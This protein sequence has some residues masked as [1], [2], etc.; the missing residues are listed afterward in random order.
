MSAAAYSKDPK[1]C[2]QKMNATKDFEI[3]DIIKHDCEDLPLFTHEKCFA[4]TAVSHTHRVITLAFRGSTAVSQIVDEMISVL[5]FHKV[6][7]P[8]G[9]KVQRYFADAHKKLYN[10]V[11]ASVTTLVKMYPEYNIV[12]T[13]H[14]L[15]GALATLAASTFAYQHVIPLRNMSIYTFG[16]PR[17]GDKN[18]AFNYDRLIN[19]SWRVVHNRDIVSHLP[20]C[21]L[22]TGCSTP[23]NGPYHHR[24]EIFYPNDTMKKNSFYKECR[25]DDSYNCSDGMIQKKPC[26]VD[27]V[28]CIEYHKYYFNLRVGTLC[29]H[30]LTKK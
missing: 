13:G 2:L 5:T 4:Y 19:N 15:G 3:K 9:G 17:V 28:D 14:S 11:N 26:T 23:D 29:Q 16:Q 24:T 27:I 18:F 22:F 30:V 7:F 20:T 6:P 10:D 25:G 1:M 8:I 21:R 12:V